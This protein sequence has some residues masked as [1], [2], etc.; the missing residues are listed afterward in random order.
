ML[1]PMLPLDATLCYQALAARDARHDGR[2]FVGV[3]STGIYC[4]PVCP[5]R[6]PKRDNCRFFAAAAGAEAAGFRPCLRCRPETAPE[7]GA[8]RGTESTVARGLD[9]IARGALD[10]PDANVEALAERLGV[11]ARHL[12]RLFDEHLGASPVAVAQ[13]RRIAFAKQLLHETLLPMSEVAI[14][15]GFGSV[16]RFN[17]TFQSMFGRPPSALRGAARSAQAQGSV[18]AAGVTLRIHYRPPYDFGG[19]LDF[20]RARAIAGVEL[21]GADRYQRT[22]EQAGEVGSVEVRHEPG[23]HALAV[24]LRAGDMRVVLPVVARVRRAF[25]VDSDVGLIGEQLSADPLL[26]R[27]V[28]QRPGLRVPG[29]FEGFELATRALLGQ[30]VSVG[31]ARLLGERL[32]RL[33]GPSVLLGTSLVRLFP[34][35]EHVANADLSRLGAPRAR[36]EALAA[37][38]EAACRDPHLFERRSTLEDTVA[39]LR[40]VRGIGP[41]TAHYIALR[42][43]RDPDAFPASD[44]GLLR[45]ILL[46]EGAAWTPTQLERRAERWRPWRAYAAQHLWAADASSATADI[47]EKTHAERA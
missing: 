26:A 43:A 35:P 37:L 27:L 7:H 9:L 23:E 21:V 29:G 31:A 13:T 10:G 32:V 18:S 40:A 28:R 44:R 17:E 33:C 20:L 8:W 14:A 2:F 22:F 34:R 36:L 30:Q 5:A 46:C 1:C 41:W 15:A 38:A 12:R 47:G 4:R 11:G 45:G 25:D 19:V 39:R 24:T 42:A 16:R 6:T 3:T